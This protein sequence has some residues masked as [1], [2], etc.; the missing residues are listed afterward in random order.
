M[1]SRGEPADLA[2]LNSEGEWK[3]EIDRAEQKA[4]TMDQRTEAQLFSHANDL[5]VRST[6]LDARLSSWT[7]A[8]SLV[9]RSRKWVQA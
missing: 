9:R 8:R 6:G 1:R 4:T 3:R 7:C 2:S 5:K